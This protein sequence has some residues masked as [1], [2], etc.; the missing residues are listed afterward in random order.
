MSYYPDSVTHPEGDE[1]Y[2]ETHCEL[3]HRTYTKHIQAD[4]E[5]FCPVPPAQ[6]IKWLENEFKKNLGT[7]PAH[8]V[9]CEVHKGTPL[10]E[11]IAKEM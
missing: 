10:L 6:A 8:R 1:Q 5:L 2:I 7:G 3:C 9:M 11:A 4:G